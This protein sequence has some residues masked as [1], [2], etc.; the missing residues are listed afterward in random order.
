MSDSKVINLPATVVRELPAG[1]LAGPYIRRE[2]RPGFSLRAII[3]HMVDDA[4]LSGLEREVCDEYRE[5]TAGLE[6]RGIRLPSSV[7]NKRQIESTPPIIRHPRIRDLVGQRV[8]EGV[9]NFREQL[10][11]IQELGGLEPGET[12]M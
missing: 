7:F 6:T 10:G 12:F 5:R 9:F 2:F 4:P 8:L 3:A 11:L 1:R